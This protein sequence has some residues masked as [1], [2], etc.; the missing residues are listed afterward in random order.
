MGC[1]DL[2]RALERERDQPA[3]DLRPDVV[4]AEPELGDDAEALA[5]AADR[6]EQVGVLV[7]ARAADRAV[8]GD[9]L[10]LEQVVDSPA[11]APREVAETAA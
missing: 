5:G 4:E 6:P 8:G 11:E 2:G 1:L 9:D 3:E 7:A 10:D